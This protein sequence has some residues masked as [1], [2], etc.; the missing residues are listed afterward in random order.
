MEQ[1]EGEL[2]GMRLL[3][4]DAT[5]AMEAAKVKARLCATYSMVITVSD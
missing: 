1:Y 2:K 5:E 3:A 4:T